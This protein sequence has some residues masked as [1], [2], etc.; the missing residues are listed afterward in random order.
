MPVGRPPVHPEGLAGPVDIARLAAPGGPLE[1]R[2][3]APPWSGGPQFADLAAQLFP[4]EFDVLDFLD[5]HKVEI[6]P[7]D[8]SA[9]GVPRATVVRYFGFTD[10]QLDAILVHLEAL[11]L[12][13]A[14]DGVVGLSTTGVQMLASRP[15]ASRPLP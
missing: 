2:T 14:H 15:A 6:A 1:V 13:G 7:G 8:F 3:A 4:I 11:A 9:Q 12:A 10:A 5:S